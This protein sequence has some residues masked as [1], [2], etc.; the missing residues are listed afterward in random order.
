MDKEKEIEKIAKIACGVKGIECVRCLFSDKE[1]K[2]NIQK[3]YAR[4]LCNAG[5][6]K[7]DEVRKET[8][9]EILQYF[10]DLCSKNPFGDYDLCDHDIKELAKKY[11]VEVGKNV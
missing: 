11:G 2:C 6:R 3:Y 9:K 10:Y 7:A 5:Y 1:G 8:A 4:R